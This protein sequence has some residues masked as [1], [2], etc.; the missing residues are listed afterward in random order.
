MTRRAIVIGGSVGGLFAASMLR[1]RG[2]T[3]DV[4]EKSPVEL[5]GRGAGIVTHQA[6]LDALDLCGAGTRDIGVHIKTRTGYD[7]AGNV[8]R[9]VAFPQIV[10]SWDRLHALTRATI[11]DAHY[12][13]D[14]S[15]ERYEHTGDGV[16]AHFS[17][18]RSETCDLLVGADGFRSAV[19][20]QMHPDVQPEYAGYVTWRGVANEADLPAD[21][22]ENDFETFGFF[23]PD[24]NEILG[25]P[26][27]GPDNDVRPGKRRYNWVWYRVIT[28][29][30]LKDMLTDEEGNTFDLTIA[31]PLIRKDVIRQLRE[32][33]E[34]FIPPQFR[35]I[36]E[37]VKAPFFTP[38][39]DLASPSMIDG[40]VALA[41]DAAFVAR[42][43][44][45]MGVT[46][47]AEDARVLA[48]ELD[49]S[50]TIEAG[51][52]S[53]NALRH[54]AGRLAFERGRHLGEF[55]MPKYKNEA[56]KAEWAAAHN[57]DTIMRDTAVADFL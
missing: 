50:S 24:R 33:A 7:R 13:L 27:A 37:K 20:G 10:T 25:Y 28:P 17:N 16:V 42:P 47:A 30:E 39:Y 38:I 14:H 8:I 1:T 5:A 23:T 22:R 31:P 53:F 15:L 41:G 35:R 46:K 32:D 3:V 36:L 55:L 56:E 26:I 45:G 43:H 51:L 29:A 6:L 12:H 11:P 54:K 40:R 52:A 21:I 44:V 9:T 57:L 49:R 19:R 4:F 34:E 18:G 48:E 2:W